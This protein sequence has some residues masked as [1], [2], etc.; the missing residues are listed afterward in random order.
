MK[1]RGAVLCRLADA[2]GE[3]RPGFGL[4][5]GRE[6]RPDDLAGRR[7]AGAQLSPGVVLPSGGRRR[8]AARVDAMQLSQ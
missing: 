4:Q 6:Q 3:V 2:A 7:Q 5:A 1:R 8:D